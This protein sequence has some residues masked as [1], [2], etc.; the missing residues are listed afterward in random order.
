MPHISHQF[1]TT[2]L[3]KES[4]L[5]L[6]DNEVIL[7]LQSL[8]GEDVL[9]FLTYIINVTSS[10]FRVTSEQSEELS[11]EKLRSFTVLK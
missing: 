2:P 9:L 6:S 3:K 1:Q 11:S 10:G 4:T 7:W 8:D 5:Q